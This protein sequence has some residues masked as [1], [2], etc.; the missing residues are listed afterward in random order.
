MKSKNIPIYMIGMAIL[1]I[2]SG[3]VSSFIINLKND[4]EE[5]LR[6]MGSVSETFEDFSTYVSLYEDER[7]SLYEKVLSSFYYDTMFSQDTLVKNKLTNYENIVDDIEKEKNLLD[8]LCNDVYYPEYS[9]NNKC[10][11]YKTIYEQVVNYFVSDIKFY[12]K[13]VD[14]YNNYVK[15][16]NGTNLI[17]KYK[18]NKKY[19]DYNKDGKFDGKEV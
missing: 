11:N 17:A 6:R 16:N 3:C 1:M 15:N 4:K 12:N 14:N 7:D 5:V 19:I 8:G 18:T 13:N 10:G 2:F 9:A